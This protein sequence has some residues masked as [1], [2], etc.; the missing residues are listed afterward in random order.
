MGKGWP[1]DGW[2]GVAMG[3]LDVGGY[4]WGGWMVVAMDMAWLDMDGHGCG[5]AG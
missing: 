2:K 1:W 4:A 3:W 5:V